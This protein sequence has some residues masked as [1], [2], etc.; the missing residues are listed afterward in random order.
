MAMPCIKSGYSYPLL[1][2]SLVGFFIFC[3][4]PAQAEGCL[5]VRKDGVIYY[6]FPRTVDKKARL[7]GRPSQTILKRAPLRRLPPQELTPVIQEASRKYSIP[8]S[9][10]K[11]VI[12]VESNFNPGALSP[13]GAQGLMQ[14]MP[15][16]AADLQ[17]ADPYDIQE[18]ILAGTRYLSL[19][20][21]KFGHKLP[22]ALAAYN[23]GPQRIDRYQGVPPIAE[24]QDFVRNVCLHFLRY[25]AKK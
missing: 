3:A 22:Y 6:F 13:K 12:Q 8:P 10:I 20:L 4:S 7:T 9:L 14:L 17:V 19:L 23:A 1:F 15:E 11:A 18:N 16:T 2:L 24:T 25:E 5:R 21:Q